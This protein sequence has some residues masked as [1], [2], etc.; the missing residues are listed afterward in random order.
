MERIYSKDVQDRLDKIDS[1]IDIRRVYLISYYRGLILNNEPY[2]IRAMQ[3]ALLSDDIINL[4]I[5]FKVKLLETATFSIIVP[6]DKILAD[7]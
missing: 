4:L 1:D 3:E 7:N 2:K 6:D 5:R